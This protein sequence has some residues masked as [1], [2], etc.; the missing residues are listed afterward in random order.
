MGTG[1]PLPI[2]YP[3][4]YSTMALSALNLAPNK[5]KSWICPW[6]LR[7]T[8]GETQQINQQNNEPASLK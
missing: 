7:A 2:I 4:V 1:I 5:C 8:S 6:L 3:I